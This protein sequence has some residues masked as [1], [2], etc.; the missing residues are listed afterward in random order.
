M[1]HSRRV[2]SLIGSFLYLAAICSRNGSA[3]EQPFE[4]ECRDG[5][6]LDGM[7]GSPEEDAAG[8]T[9]KIVILLHGS[10]P[11]SMDEDLSLATEG[12]KQNLFFK[13]ISDALVDVGFTVV[14]Y[15]KRTYQCNLKIAEDP[16]FAESETFQSYATNWL[17]Y[18]VDDAIDCVRHMQDTRPEA[19]I[20]LLG[21]SQ[22][23]YVG[24]QAAHQVSE[25]KGVALVGFALAGMETLVLEQVVYRAMGHFRNLDANADKTL[26]ADELAV[27]DPVA[28]A[29]RPQIPVID[30]DGDGTISDIE[31]K[32]GNLS[33]LVIADMGLA[34]FTRQE[35][36]YPRLADILRD[37][38]FKVI[39]LQG[40]WDNQTPA[41]N[42]KAVE[43]AARHVWMKEN[44]RFTYFPELGHALDRRDNYEDVIYDT[45]HPE[46]KE[47]LADQLREFF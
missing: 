44:F 21:H 7:I 9:E 20:C 45:I 19:E 33:N 37:A 46:A 36:T 1:L 27:D 23:C 15:H 31:F 6:V 17:K 2:A 28:A 38:Q 32:A 16:R 24:L 40:L 14:R 13:E 34:A 35:A 43:L 29:L 42:A 18:F 4:L 41:Y 25:I 3:D 47:T 5:F 22:G 12:G 39:F 8:E 30:Q 11:Q 26:D 10:G